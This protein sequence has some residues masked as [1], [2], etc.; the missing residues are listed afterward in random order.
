[1]LKDNSSSLIS[2]GLLIRD[3]QMLVGLFN[4]TGFFCILV[5]NRNSIAYNLA[6]H[7][8]HITGLSVWMEDVP[9][10]TLAA[11]QV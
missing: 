5:E 11:Y 4:C 2:F 7:A 10:H 6:R 9:F 1:M 8:C 3:A